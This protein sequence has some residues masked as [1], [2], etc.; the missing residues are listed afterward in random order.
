MRRPGLRQRGF[1]FSK[2]LAFSVRV[3]LPDRKGETVL[4]CERGALRLAWAPARSSYNPSV[5]AET[6]GYDADQISWKRP[7]MASASVSSYRP[8]APR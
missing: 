2:N 3:N 6:P 8:S 5:A 1:R 7:R 4:Y